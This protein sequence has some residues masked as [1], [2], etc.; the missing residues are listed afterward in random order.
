MCAVDQSELEPAQRGQDMALET[1]RIA[2]I[3]VGSPVGGHEGQPALRVLLE[4]DVA[5][6]DDRQSLANSLEDLGREFVRGLL[7]RE[8]GP[9]T[10]TGGVA[11]VNLQTPRSL[12]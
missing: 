2:P 7:S 5:V 12:W 6:L 9:M 4:R 8:Q 10:R 11:V 3:G 1:L